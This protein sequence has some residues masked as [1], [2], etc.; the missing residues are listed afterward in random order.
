MKLIKKLLLITLNLKISHDDL[1]ELIKWQEI[2]NFSEPFPT[3]IKKKV[4]KEYSSSSTIWVETGTLVGDTA[5]YLSKIAKFVYT[6][7]P[8]EKYYNLSVKNLKNYENIK[9]YND[10]SE[11]KL[12]DIL[13]IIKPNSDV[14]FWLDGHWSGGDTFKGETDTPIL[15]ELD[16]IERYLNNFSKLNILIDDFRIF[17]I[18]NNVDTYP[19][20][21]VLIEYAAK[22]NLKWRITR[23][24]IILSKEGIVENNI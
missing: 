8:S 10:T 20:K 4:L 1:N 7:E 12:N 24:I 23:D 11:N 14:C 16:T 3:F 5:K 22:N 17:D 15:S 13:E 9:I 19:S 18:G 2:Y 6:I 21:E